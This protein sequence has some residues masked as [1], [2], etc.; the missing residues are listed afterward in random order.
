MSPLALVVVLLLVLLLGGG[1]AGSYAP[2]GYGYGFHHG[3]IGVIGAVLIVILILA[4]MGR[5]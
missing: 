4:L 3:G 2:W 5:F 1:L